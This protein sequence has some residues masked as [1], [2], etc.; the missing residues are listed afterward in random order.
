MNI[1]EKMEC[2]FHATLEGGLSA[3]WK[4]KEDFFS[5]GIPPH[6]LEIMPKYGTVVTSMALLLKASGRRG[7]PSNI[8]FQLSQKTDFL[9]VSN[10]SE[11][12]FLSRVLR[13][14]TPIFYLQKIDWP[15]PDDPRKLLEH[16][17]FLKEL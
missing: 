2:R 16:P 5:Q 3:F 13:Q 9:L 14:P 11:K 7:R 8:G 6:L 10:G 12:G 17:R 4:T 1:Q 15:H